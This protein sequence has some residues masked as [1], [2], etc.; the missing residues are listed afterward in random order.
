MRIRLM[1]VFSLSLIVLTSGGCVPTSGNSSSSFDKQ[2]HTITQPYSFNF[3]TW[4]FN[5]LF[6]DLKQKTIDRPSDS[7]LNSQS[8]FNYFSYVSQLNSLKSDLRIFQATKMQ[9]D[10]SQYETK[11][12][13]IDTQIA[14]LKPVAEQ[15]I[16]RQVSQIL[17]EQGIYNPF[18]TS[19]FKVPFPAVNFKLEKPLYELILSPRDKIQRIQSITI[20][21]DISPSQVEEV[22]SSVDKLNVS[23]LVVQ[24]GGLGATYPS[25]VSDNADL[26]FTINTAAHEW[27]HQYLAFKPLGFHY[28]LD[29][30]GISKDYQI[31][32]INETVASMF[33]D[34]IGD[35]VYD[36]DYSQYQPANGDLKVNPLRSGFDY[37]KSM[38]EIRINVDTY[39]ALGQVD[40]AEQYMNEQQKYLATKGY[41]I[42]KLNQAYFAFY[43]TYANGPSSVDPIGNEVRTL[44]KQSLSIKDFLDK[45]SGFTNRQDLTNAVRQVK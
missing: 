22:E 43:G 37:N 12:S 10:L 13:E 3:A 21:P 5:T 14:A 4:E 15:T 27:L 8:V 29:L 11:I 31:D 23:A 38:R 16:A 41:Y 1:L 40:Q 19:W 34:E 39:L 20:K 33:G 2:F 9:G 7:L 18:G 44:R 36:K 32:T 17:D 28:I 26:R 35:M 6:N 30:L 25:F 42:R 24:I 45:A